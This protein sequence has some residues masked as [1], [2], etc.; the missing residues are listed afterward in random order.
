MGDPGLWQAMVVRRG[1][2]STSIAALVLAAGCS[3]SPS[4][5]TTPGGPSLQYYPHPGLGPILADPNGRVL[6][7]FTNDEPGTS[8]CYDACAANWP[9]YLVDKVASAPSDVDDELDL[10]ERADGKKQLAYRDRPLYFWSKAERAG[11]ATGDGI[12]GVWFVVRQPPADATD[13]FRRGE[14]EVDAENVTY[15]GSTGYFAQPRGSE[16][17][18]GVVLIHEWWGLND[19]IREMALI[20][21]SHGYRVLAVDLFEGKVAATPAEAQGQV[22]AMDQSE[23]NATMQAAADY[24]RERGATEII[25]FGWCFGGGQSLQF[26]LSGESLVATV[27][28]Y[29]RLVNDSEQLAPLRWPVLGIFGEKDPVVSVESVR[30]FEQAITNETSAHEFYI[31]PDV[32]HAFANPS[33]AWAPEEAADAWERTLIFLARHGLAVD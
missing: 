3:S 1:W 27:I 16:S 15:H 10:V 13:P 9:P 8:K 33:N 31:Y 2:L 26:A 14:H 4:A 19:N 28:Y 25:S 22:A 17:P 29:G 21:A 5:S 11:D 12:S 32:G 24:L 20:L 18:T 6:Y 23:A 7:V 30:G